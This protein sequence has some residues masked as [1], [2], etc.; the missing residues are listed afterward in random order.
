MVIDLVAKCDTAKINE[1][2]SRCK[3]CL[4]LTLMNH[5]N[6]CERVA[7]NYRPNPVEARGKQV[8]TT[9]DDYLDNWILDIGF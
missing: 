3:F 4:Q 1:E 2:E 6:D 9:V 7:I 8:P 5:A